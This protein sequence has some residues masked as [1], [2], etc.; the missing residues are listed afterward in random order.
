MY[1]RIESRADGDALVVSYRDENSPARRILYEMPPVGGKKLRVQLQEI[2]PSLTNGKG[3]LKALSAKIQE[4]ILQAWI[5][6][7]TQEGRERR[8]K[9]PGLTL[10]ILLATDRS[11]LL[12]NNAST[13]KDTTIRDDERVLERMLDLYGDCS[14]KEVTPQMCSSWLASQSE[15]AQKDCRRV[16]LA[17]ERLQLQAGALESL[18]WEDY[19]PTTIRRK[20]KSS[21]SLIKRQLEPVM[22]TDGQCERILKNIKNC[23]NRGQATGVDMAILLALTAGLSLECISALRLNDF[24]FLDDFKSRLTVAITRKVTKAASSYVCREIEDPYE[25][26]VTPLPMLTVE[27]YKVLMNKEGCADRLLTPLPNNRH[28]RMSPSKLREAMA[29]RVSDVQLLR[30]TDAKGIK[31]SSVVDML[32][33]TGL[34]ELQKAGLEDE[35]LRALCGQRPRLVS[36]KHYYDRMNEAALNKIGAIQDRWVQRVCPNVVAQGP[37]RTVLTAKGSCV[38]WV[39]PHPGQHTQLWIDICIP[40]IPRECIPEGGIKIELSARHGI[41]GT[42]CRGDRDDKT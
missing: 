29:T 7:D 26:R 1:Y 10:G 39:A 9:T 38:G 42:I 16:M 2:I 34:C 21:K 6:L 17:F 33:P 4:R 8:K 40:P 12:C 20:S 31:L 18:T 32:G 25:R 11:K 3:L 13:R 36:G 22:L 27:C 14:W 24:K 28:R 23:I 37:K 19:V 15:R 5:G 35:E 30:T 41:I